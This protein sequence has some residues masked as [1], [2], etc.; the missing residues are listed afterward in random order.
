[1]FSISEVLFPCV[2]SVIFLRIIYVCYLCVSCVC[3]IISFS[4][5]RRPSNQVNLLF[6]LFTDWSNQTYKDK[7]IALG[8]IYVNAGDLDL[9][10]NGSCRSQGTSQIKGHQFWASK[11]KT[12]LWKTGGYN[13]N[14]K[15]W[16]SL[17]NVCERDMA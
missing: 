15:H 12:S 9:H 14:N 4:A 3:E 8:W 1:M 2:S 10:I 11:Y 17:C 7:S 16:G 13:K 6:L 5:Q